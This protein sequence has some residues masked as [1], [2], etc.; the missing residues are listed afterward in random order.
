MLLLTFLCFSQ[1]RLCCHTFDLRQ[2]LPK[3]SDKRTFFSK[4]NTTLVVPFYIN[5]VSTHYLV[6]PEILVIILIKNADRSLHSLL[7]Q[8][9]FPWLF[10]L[11]AFSLFYDNYEIKYLLNSSA[12]INLFVTTQEEPMSFIWLKK[13]FFI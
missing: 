3:Y 13:Q 10:T 1:S 6:Y 8:G 2:K 11:N 7:N 12:T 5:S 4:I 9:S